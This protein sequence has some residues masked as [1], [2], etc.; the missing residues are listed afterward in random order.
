MAWD[1]RLCVGIDV[2][3]ED[4]KR[5]VD[6]VNELHRSITSQ[7][8]AEVSVAIFDRLADATRFH[9]AREEALLDETGYEDTAEHKRGH[10][11]LI[12]QIQDLKAKFRHNVLTAPP[13]LIMDFLKDW[14]TEHILISDKKYVS[15]LSTRHPG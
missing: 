2:I 11:D 12:L 8:G 6:L 13:A 4:H 10:H 9:F 15:H 7:A 1:E 14:L 5:L 3:D